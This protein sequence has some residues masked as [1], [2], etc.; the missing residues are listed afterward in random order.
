M[1]LFPEKTL[2]DHS[3]DVGSYT[4][5]KEMFTSIPDGAIL[6]LKLRRGSYGWITNKDSNDEIKFTAYSVAFGEIWY[7]E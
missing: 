4:F 1:N 7:L 6:E 2:I 5:K 3:D